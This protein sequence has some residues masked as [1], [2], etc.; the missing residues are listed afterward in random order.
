M[1]WIVAG[2]L[3]VP[4]GD[5]V[6]KA[7]V[8]VITRVAWSRELTGP[9]ERSKTFRLSDR[10]T[11][12][13]SADTVV[14][15]RITHE[16]RELTLE[17]GRAEFT[18]SRDERPFEVKAGTTQVVALGTIF[19]VTRDNEEIVTVVMRGEVVV[20]P[21]PSQEHVLAA[22]QAAWVR[23][24][25]FRMQPG[26]SSSDSWLKLENGDFNFF[27]YPLS[28]AVAAFNDY[29]NK[30]RLEIVDPLLRAATI[31]GQFPANNPQRFAR[32]LERLRIAS[33]QGGTA[34][35]SA[36][37]RLQAYGGAETTTRDSE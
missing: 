14:D 21:A 10:S 23:G 19:S 37:I 20:I 24:D 31:G 15:W 18:V 34:S 35:D 9:N 5:P 12:Q 2:C 11:V 17:R 8:P 30:Q 29:H 13:L 27:K 7:N 28:G 1:P 4:V 16:R 36:V 25:R 32:A 6:R 3:F 22:G 26:P 33:I